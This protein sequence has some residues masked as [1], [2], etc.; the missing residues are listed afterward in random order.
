MGKGAQT[1]YKEVAKKHA[2]HSI[3]IIQSQIRSPSSTSVIDLSTENP[4]VDNVIPLYEYFPATAEVNNDLPASGSKSQTIVPVIPVSKSSIL[5]NVSILL[6]NKSNNPNEGLSESDVGIPVHV[7]Q[8]LSQLHST[9]TQ[10]HDLP[11]NPIVSEKDFV[12]TPTYIIKPKPIEESQPDVET[13]EADDVSTKPA[14]EM[15]PIELEIAHPRLN[16]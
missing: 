2:K 7:S 12:A 13:I 10:L 5:P 16:L 3:Q 4:V 15:S 11:S 1:G 6:E 8:N 9:I 14:V